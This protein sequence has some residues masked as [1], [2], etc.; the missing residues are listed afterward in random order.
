MEGVVISV[1]HE[2]CLKGS[3]R[4]YTGVTGKV[5]LHVG[6]EMGDV[7]VEGSI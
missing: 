6:R 7:F 4:K 5:E 1:D 3:K 2:K